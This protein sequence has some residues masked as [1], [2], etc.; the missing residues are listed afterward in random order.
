MLAVA[1]SGAAR[2]RAGAEELLLLLALLL[3][4][5]AVPLPLILLFCITISY[6]SYKPSVVT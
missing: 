5:L 6:T 3:D 4:E 2:L 1:S